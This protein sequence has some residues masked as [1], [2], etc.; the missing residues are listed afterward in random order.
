MEEAKVVGVQTM[1]VVVWGGRRG[2]VLT[3]PSASLLVA[4]ES[5]THCSFSSVE[6][7]RATTTTTETRGNGVEVRWRRGGA[8]GRK[9]ERF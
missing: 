8:S 9:V 7:A 4:D 2:A 6:R 3:L 1:T 5:H